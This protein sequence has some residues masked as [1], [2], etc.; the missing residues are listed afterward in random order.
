MYLIT[1]GSTEVIAE[2]D[3][4]PWIDL[5][6]NELEFILGSTR[7]HNGAMRAE[8]GH[9]DPW[10]LKYVEIGNE[11]NLWGGEPSYIAYRWQMFYDA[12]HKKWPDLILI[13]STQDMKVA[14]EGSAWDYH[15]YTR[16]DDFVTNNN[17][18]DNV[19]RNHTSLQG[20]YANIEGNILGGG[21]NNWSAPQLEWPQW[22]GAVSESVWTLGIERNGDVMIGAS[23]AP[24]FQNRNKWQWAVCLPL[25][26]KTLSMI[27]EQKLTTT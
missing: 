13:S 25:L 21:G 11:D 22:V 1:N 5:A 2:A 14:G 9:P 19:P 27:G 18:W 26:S 23:Y 4:Q 10:P 24:G 16:P 20:E 15:I 3:L 6:M 17:Y 12:I 8:L 7:T